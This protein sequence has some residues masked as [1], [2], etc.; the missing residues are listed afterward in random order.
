M[1]CINKKKGVTGV[2]LA[3][4]LARRMNHQDKG[5]VLYHGQPLVC[6]AVKAMSQVVETVLISANRNRE[7]YLKFSNQV[8]ADLTHDFAGPLAGILSAMKYSKSPL[9]CVIPCDS[10]M[11]KANH[12]NQ[13]IEAL[14]S[15]DMAIAVADDGSRIQPVFLALKT[16]LADSLESYLKSG[17]G[18]IDRWLLQH[19]LIKVDFS[20]DPSLFLNI[21]TLDELKDLE[22]QNDQ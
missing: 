9:L 3:G 22:R 13:L 2:I 17:Q 7:Q 18:K 19:P 5:L 6:Y 20:T 8:I 10:P 21:N 1:V 11:I 14:V 12:I 16:S 15:S 4:G